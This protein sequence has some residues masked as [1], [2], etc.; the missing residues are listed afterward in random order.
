V[1]NSKVIK[2]IPYKRKISLILLIKTAF[3]ADLLAAIRVYQKFINK[4]EQI[5]T[6]SQPKNINNKLSDTNKKSI[7]KVNRFKY[8]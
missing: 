1:L 7:K 4:Y 2:T 6:P 3:K 8:E 5:P